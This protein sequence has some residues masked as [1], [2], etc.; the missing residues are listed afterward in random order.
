MVLEYETNEKEDR[1]KKIRIIWIDK[2]YIIA[3]YVPI[4]GECPVPKKISIKDL[5][6]EIERDILREIDDP[7]A[8]VIVEENIPDNYKKQRDEYWPIIEHLWRNNKVDVLKKETRTKIIKGAAIK[9]NTY[10]KKI[11][12]LISRFWQRGM[13]RNTLLPDYNNCGGKGKEKKANEA[14]RGKPRKCSYSGESVDGINVDDDIKS[15]IRT[16]IEVFYYSGQKKTLKETYYLMLERFFSDVSFDKGIRYSKIW[17]KELIPTY[18]QFYYWYRKEFNFKKEYV[19]RNSEK[20]FELQKR[21]LLSNS[22]QETF[23]PG[24]RY[25]IDATIGDV[26]LVSFSQPDRIIGRP[27]VYIV[28]DVYSRMITGLYVGLEGPSWIGAMMALDNV[29]ADK[30]EF[31]RQ[32]GIEISENDWPNSYLPETIIADRGEFKGYTVENLINNLNIK[33]ENTSPYRGDLK[34]IVERNFRTTNEKIKHTTPGAIQKEFR[35]RGDRDYRLD[36]TLNL[37]EFTSIMVYEILHHNKS[38]IEKYPREK[39]LISDNVSPIPIEMWKWGLANRSCGFIKKDRDIIRLNLMPHDSA[40]ITREGIKF[41]KLY[42]SCEEAIKEQWFTNPQKMKVDIVY[43]PRNM[44]YIYISEDNGKGFIKC[45]MME[46]SFMYKNLQ[47]EEIVFCYELEN[48]IKESYTDY[49][50][51]NKVDLEMNIKNIIK[52]ATDKTK[53]KSNKSDISRLK[54]IRE[55]RADEKQINRQIEAFELNKFKNVKAPNVDTRTFEKENIDQN[56]SFMPKSK[57]DLLKRKR[58]EKIGK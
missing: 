49:N 56:Q 46:K 10:D 20:E 7:Y 53:G 30:V 24:S 38:I 3:Y 14:K 23:G 55:N 9:F 8:T 17:G 31:C 32:Y 27:V 57:L 58:D 4:T 12:R 43:D 52:K 26:Y 36:A 6:L 33:I 29:V 19:S 28:I 1:R 50:N 48:E 40:T 47:L 39:G 35:E 2:G 45:F 13:T 25:Q 51:Q 34:G 11:I 54:N 37:N 44:N 41:K 42:Y 5:E 21:E 15:K 22:T 18:Q 16:A